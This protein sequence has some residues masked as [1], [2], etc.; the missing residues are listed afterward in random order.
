MITY[1]ELLMAFK[2]YAVPIPLDT[3]VELE[4]PLNTEADVEAVVEVLPDSG[5]ACMGIRRLKLTTEAEVYGNVIISPWIS[6]V[7]DPADGIRLEAADVD[8]L[9]TDHT[10]YA[11]NYRT[12]YIY[13]DKLWL[14]GRVKTTTTAARKVI[15]KCAGIQIKLPETL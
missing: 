10:I 7:N 1:E 8:E 9:T 11:S 5:Y 13:C 4:F 2:Q 15:C 6:P 3:P 12:D 14:Y